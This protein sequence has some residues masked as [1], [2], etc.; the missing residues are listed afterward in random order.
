MIA[1]GYELPNEVRLEDLLKVRDALKSDYPVRTEQFSVQFQ[2]NVAE[3]LGKSGPSELEGYRLASSDGKR[4]VRVT[5]GDFAFSQLAPYDR[6]ETLHAEAERIWTI[7]ERI[8]Q[9]RRITRVAVR[10]INRIDMPDPQGSGVD[11]D[12]YF[13]AAPK[14]PPELP[15]VMATYFVRL[16]LPF[17]TPDG[18]LI[19][20]LTAA[21][22][23]SAGFVSAL[24]DLDAVIQNVDMD[25]T[26]AWRAIEELRDVKNAA[27]EAS[28]TDAAREL[29]K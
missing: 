5:L 7:L 1:I 11:L 26:R 13:H 29:F 17:Q 25:A 15:Q 6:W 20:T 22:P 12:V 4:I 9:P 21:S 18:I 24:L 10:F 8:L 28:I 27:F 16:E 23:T 14:I 2:L 19:L 3:R